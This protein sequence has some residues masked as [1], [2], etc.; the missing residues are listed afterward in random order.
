MRALQ[1]HPIYEEILYSA[2]V[3]DTVRKWNVTNCSMLVEK[4]LGLSPHSMII[5]SDGTYLVVGTFEGS[6]VKID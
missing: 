6:V 4:S 5:N 2:N 3:D 1:F